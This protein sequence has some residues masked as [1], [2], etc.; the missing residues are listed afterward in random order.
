[1]SVTSGFFNSLNGDRKYNA[2]QMSAIFDGII[3][4][5]VFIS[6]GDA[7]AVN[8]NNGNTIT[9]G[10]GRA[11]FNS[12]WIYNDATLPL[13]AEPSETLLDRYDAVVIEIN[14]SEAVRT[15]TIKIVKGV[16]SSNPMLPTMVSTEEVHQYPLAFIYRKAETTE[17]KQSD[18]TN[19]VGTSACPYVTGILQVQNIDNIV[20]QWQD[21]WTRWMNAEQTE[22]DEW[23][24]SVKD[25][26][27]EDAAGNLQLQINDKRDK[28]TFVSIA[29]YLPEVTA[30]TDI[31]TIMHQVDSGAY[32]CT[33]SNTPLIKFPDVECADAIIVWEK[34]KNPNTDL[35]YGTLTVMSMY[36]KDSSGKVLPPIMYIC[37]IYNNTSYTEWL[38]V[39]DLA[40]Y[41]PLTGGF[42]S[43]NIAFLNYN[44]YYAIQKARTIADGTTHWLT[45][46]VGSDG[47]TTLEH[48]TGNDTDYTKAVQDCRLE[49]RSMSKDLV[50][51]LIL[52]DTSKAVLYQIYGAHNIAASRTELGYV[53]GVTSAIQTQLDDLKKKDLRYGGNYT[54]LFSPTLSTSHE[55][56]NKWVVVQGSNINNAP[57]S[58]IQW[59]EVF[60][61]GNKSAP[62]AFQIAI[63]CFSSDRG[64]YIRWLHDSTWSGWEAFMTTTGNQG[65]SSLTS[66][67]SKTSGNSWSLS[68][69][70]L[71]LY[72]YLTFAM[73]DGDGRIS[74]TRVPIDLVSTTSTKYVLNPLF[75]NGGD[76]AKAWGDVVIVK[77]G[78]TVTVTYTTRVQDSCTISNCTLYLER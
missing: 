46:G 56:W 19:M 29:D 69:T 78:T 36:R 35:V 27:S 1:M 61:G 23:F 43:G 22:F 8:A 49:M 32:A 48:Y 51:A 62:R 66:Q 73:K 4:D 55:A 14:R 21:M 74:L 57:K 75:G 40:K 26:L 18:I 16:P 34:Q 3:N 7:F 39:A 72:S 58:G 30:E 20:A 9:I 42:L 28:N 5:G 63:A 71:A 53:K 44:A 52:R 17:I 38:G 13:T 70:T 10:V 50:N 12:T 64:I 37:S 25:Q 65:P 33:I 60:T 24:D 67:G 11:W 41:L 45:M 31:R 15:G 68:T 59:Y 6:V 54:D 47:A 2:E 77:S 76:T